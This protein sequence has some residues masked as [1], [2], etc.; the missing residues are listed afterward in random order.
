MRV[1][2]QVWMMVIQKIGKLAGMI[3]RERSEVHE[4]K[5]DLWE[6]KNEVMQ[7]H[8]LIEQDQQQHPDEY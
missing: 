4:K 5:I 8:E 7:L 1:I 6:L 2:D 3:Q